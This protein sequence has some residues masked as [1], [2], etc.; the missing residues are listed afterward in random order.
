MIGCERYLCNMDAKT[1]Y[2]NMTLD[3]LHVEN[4]DYNGLVSLDDYIKEAVSRYGTFV[5][6]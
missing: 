1:S 4:G 3:S 6:R 5:I 2:V